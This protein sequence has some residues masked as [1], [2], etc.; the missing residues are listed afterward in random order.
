VLLKIPRTSF[1]QLNFK[2][3]DIQSSYSY[4]TISFEFITGACRLLTAIQGSLRQQPYIILLYCSYINACP[5]FDSWYSMYL[6]VRHHLSGRHCDVTSENM[7]MITS[8]EVRISGT[9]APRLLRDLTT[10]SYTN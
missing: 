8:I 3:W 9:L 6:T 2:E 10:G 5:R 4:L 7:D 1:L